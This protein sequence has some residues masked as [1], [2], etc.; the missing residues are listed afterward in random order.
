MG[1][2]AIVYDAIIEFIERRFKKEKIRKVK[3]LY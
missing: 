3:R 1:N 2:N